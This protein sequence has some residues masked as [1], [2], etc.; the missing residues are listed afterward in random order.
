VEGS[1]EWFWYHSTSLISAIDK[2][3][4]NHS[5][6]SKASNLIDR[7][8]CW[9]F[10]GPR[11]PPGL[12]RKGNFE[13]PGLRYCG[14]HYMYMYWQKP[15]KVWR[16]ANPE[17]ASIALFQIYL[18]KF[19]LPMSV[20]GCGEIPLLSY[21]VPAGQSM[22]RWSKMSR[23]G[24]WSLFYINSSCCGPDKLGGCK[25]GW[26]PSWSWAFPRE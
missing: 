6:N 19:R 22:Y 8:E 25:V 15:R 16:Q 12:C 20:Y 26:E 24:T 13:A 4:I 14:K 18:E 2:L 17:D 11:R 21:L 10:I 1:I 7:L 5:I 3:A 23:L 9:I